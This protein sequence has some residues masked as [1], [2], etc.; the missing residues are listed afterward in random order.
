MKEPNTPMM[1]VRDWDGL[2]ENNRSR[3]MKNTHWFPMPNDLSADS[4]VELLAHPEGTAHLGVW[5]GVLMVASR[6]KPR[7]SLVR[8]GGRPH[9]SESLALVIRQPEPVVRAAI[10]RLLQI[11][12]LEAEAGNSPR[13]NRLPRHPSALRR[14][15]AAV[16]PQ[17]GAVEQKGT[18]HHHQEGNGKEKKGTE[19]AGDEIKTERS[20]AGSSA[21]LFQRRPDDEEKPREVYASLED[22]LKAIYLT[23]AGAP[24]TIEVLGA[25]RENLELRGVGMGDFVAALKESHIQSEWRTPAG[26][27]R[28]FSKRFRSKTRVAARPVTA[29]EAEARD[30][31]CPL[32]HSKTPG[33]GAVLA[34]GKEV[35]CS[36]ASPEYIARKRARGVFAPE[37][38]PK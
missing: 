27:L 11:G 15:E 35:P 10:G 8:E 29:A 12:L 14:H 31:K 3:R 1:R 24:I 9:D 30:Y 4:Y 36:C 19:R 16:E 22:E 34:D 25:I 32:C 17:E 21:H 18:E 33:E 5:A 2:Y 6:A 28:D 38:P 7:G 26:F 23:K 20:G 13:K 37:E